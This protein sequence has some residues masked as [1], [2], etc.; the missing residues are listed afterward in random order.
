[1]PGNRLGCAGELQVAIVPNC[2]AGGGAVDFLTSVSSVRFSRV[3]DDISSAEIII[4]VGNRPNCCG[5]L[6]NVRSWCHWIQIHREGEMVWEGPI[7]NIT[8]GREEIRIEARDV[9][10]YLSIRA[11]IGTL[12]NSRTVVVN[13]VN[14][15][16][17]AMEI[18]DLAMT[19]INAAFAEHNP[20]VLE[21]VTQTDIPFRPTQYSQTLVS[22]LDFPAYENTY[23][24]WIVDLS[25]IGL[26]ITAFGRRILLGAEA[27]VVPPIGTLWDEHILTDVEVSLDGLDVVNRVYVRYR[28]DDTI[29]Q[30]QANCEAGSIGGNPPAGC[31]G[32]SA[33][34]PGTC[35]TVPCPALVEADD[36]FCYGPVER[37][38]DFDI[39][40][41]FNTAKAAG[42]A[43]ID[44]GSGTPM[45][46]DFPAGAKLAPD[47]PFG[48]ND[49]IPGGRVRVALQELCIP[50]FQDFQILE[51]N[52]FLDTDGNE[53]V[54][55]TLGPFNSTAIG[56]GGGT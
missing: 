21:Y 1:M 44:A 9:L 43:F 16:P 48:I 24:D 42:Q 56:A 30:C 3:L 4:P 31:S 53:E 8:F 46:I 37:I 7:T 5:N 29:A 38:V 34:D 20:C 49:I 11:A 26:D 15:F 18:T 2:V 12:D 17:D 36:F 10:A 41:D 28:N 23:W 40:F 14:T 52:Y 6:A 50:V 33:T 13:G 39:P 25:Q 54:T 47:T 32:C 45:R 27:I 55:M 35:L 19:V 51:L 22:E